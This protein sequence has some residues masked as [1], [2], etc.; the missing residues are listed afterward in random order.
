[1]VRFKGEQVVAIVAES[2]AAA[3]E[4]VGTVKIDYEELPAVF[5]VE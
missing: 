2:A 3:R 5:D 4:A 1:M